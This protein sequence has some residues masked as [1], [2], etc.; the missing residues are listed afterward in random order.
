MVDG[1]VALFIS[2]LAV[3]VEGLFSG[4]ILGI[5][6]LGV[7]VEIGPVHHFDGALI[8]A[9]LLAVSIMHVPKVATVIQVELI[10]VFVYGAE[11]VGGIAIVLFLGPAINS[12]RRH[13]A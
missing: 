2:V 1:P 13:A 12:T 7:P 4:R 3:D 10:W 9:Q 6:H 8:A 5:D 11:R